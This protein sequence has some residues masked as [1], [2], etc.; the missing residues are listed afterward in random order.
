ML[1]FD[2]C[3]VAAPANG[4][5]RR[6]PSSLRTDSSCQ[7]RSNRQ[8][9]FQLVPGRTARKRVSPHLQTQPRYLIHSLP[10]AQPRGLA[11]L[12]LRARR[13]Q[14]WLKDETLEDSANLPDPDV[15]AQEIGSRIPIR[16]PFGLPVHVVRSRDLHCRRPPSR[17]CAIRRNCFGLKK[18]AEA[19]SRF[20]L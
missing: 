10:L 16:S 6:S 5:K 4:A 19:I 13:L 8:D 18:V 20:F 7:I 15:I 11:R 9:R 2:D 12:V 1:G 3:G 17:A 14:F